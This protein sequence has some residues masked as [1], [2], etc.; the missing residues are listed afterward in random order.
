MSDLMAPA[1]AASVDW[2]G[3]VGMVQ[4]ADRRHVEFYRGQVLNGVRS[5]AEGR[6][7]YEPV[8]MVKIIHPGER[9]VHHLKVRDNHKYEF[10]RQWAA[11]EAGRTADADGTPV[12][13]L[14]PN[15]E[16]LVAQFKL[17]H[18]FTVEQLGGLTE[19]GIS[20]LGMGG[21]THVERAQKFLEASRGMAGAHRLQAEVDAANERADAMAEK[22]A[23]MER[24]LAALA[25]PRRRR[26]AADNPNEGD[27]E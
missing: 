10:P 9:D 14:Y 23:L 5:Q 21:R 4:Q 3:H 2:Q 7:I 11:Y 27:D 16:M 18:I 25:A 20:R 6:P 15:D 1:G 12:S 8:D 22:M 17:L 19:A 26:N 24:Q 13:M